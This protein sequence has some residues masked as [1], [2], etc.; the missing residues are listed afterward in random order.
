MMKKNSKWTLMRLTLQIIAYANKQMNHSISYSDSIYRLPE[1]LLLPSYSARLELSARGHCLFINPWILQNLYV[2][3]KYLCSLV[4]H[5]YW[6]KGDATLPWRVRDCWLS[7]WHCD[8]WLNT[9]CT[10]H[11]QLPDMVCQSGAFNMLKF[12]RLLKKKKK[13]KKRE[14][15]YQNHNAV[16]NHT[17]LNNTGGWPERYPHIKCWPPI[18]TINFTILHIN[19]KM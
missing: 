4:L 15:I 14:F 18:V 17:T 2:S 12:V 11:C 5:F 9:F 10:S 7:L 19:T 8:C 3:I 13:K 1:E 6:W 16:N